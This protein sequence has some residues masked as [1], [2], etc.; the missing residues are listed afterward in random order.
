[1]NHQIKRECPVCAAVYNADP[2]RLKH[3]RQTTCSRSCSYQL[4]A[5]V[6][7]KRTEHTCPVCAKNFFRTPSQ[8]KAKHGSTCCSSACAYQ[9]RQRVVSAPYTIT[10][11]YDRRAAILKAWVTRRAKPPSYPDSARVKARAQLIENLKRLGGVSKFEVKV[12][13]VLRTLGFNVGCSAYARN[14]N[15][16]FGCVYD[17][18][19]PERRLIIECHGDYWHGG[20][21]TWDAPNTAQ[22][23]NLIYEQRKTV[24]AITMGFDLRILWESQFKKDPV[25]AVLSV[26]R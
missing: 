5:N 18:V 15:G 9:V 6:L 17:L 20:R 26:V 23:K 11:V 22:V 16:T 8:V 4:R 12:A 13:K 7:E 21:W 24:A 19:L 25:G 10:A 1:M 3:G 14:T 2:A